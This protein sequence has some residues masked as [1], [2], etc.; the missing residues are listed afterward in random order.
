M[1]EL[2]WVRAKEWLAAE[3]DQQ[4]VMLDIDSGNYFGLNGTAAVIW[5]VLEHPHSV[6]GIVDT[7]RKQFDVS[8]ERCESSVTQTLRRLQEI[9]AI[10]TV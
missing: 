4:L 6:A 9:G 2:Q 7:L 1:P 8:R 10:S 3:F 5:T